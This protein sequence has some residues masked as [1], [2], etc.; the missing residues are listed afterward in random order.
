MKKLNT[1]ILT[2][3][4]SFLFIP[5]AQANVVD[6]VKFY[7]KNYYYEPVP[8][9]LD[10]MTTV[11]EISKALDAHS[12]YMSKE[13]YAMYTALLGIE[14]AMDKYALVSGDPVRKSH[15]NSAM[16]YGNTG[17][18]QITSFT[19]NLGSAVEQHWATL[20]K[21]G[22]QTLIIDLRNNGGGYVDSAQQLL[23]FFEGVTSSFHIKTRQ[24]EKAIPVLQAKTKFPKNTYLLI[25]HQSA[26]ASEMVAVSVKDQHAATI[27]GEQSHGK[28]TI[29]SFFKLT[30]EGVLKLTTGEFTGTAGTKVNKIGILPHHKAAKGE[31]LR[32]AHRLIIEKSLKPMKSLHN[33]DTNTAIELKLPYKMN[34][35]GD[36]AS[37]HIELVELGGK[38]VPITVIQE[39]PETLSITPNTALDIDAEYA[40]IIKPKTQR[41]NGKRVT[42]G[43]SVIITVNLATKES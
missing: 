9:N 30:N 23:G 21:E 28:G 31:E 19:G 22:A 37:H 26:S 11:E 27:I 8:S 10:K 33:I 4:L 2:I 40:A 18:I 12:Y 7:V 29:Q 38:A 6:E 42:S 41:L 34:F 20:K 1:A 36:D 25:N 14:I 17:Y 35:S 32:V 16:L 43:H 13:E 3:I 5:A 15:V 39:N 24:G